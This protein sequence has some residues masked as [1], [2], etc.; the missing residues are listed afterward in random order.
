MLGAEL[1]QLAANIVTNS[2][3]D[4]GA[5]HMYLIAGADT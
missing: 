2:F 5:E 1:L 3:P 4:F